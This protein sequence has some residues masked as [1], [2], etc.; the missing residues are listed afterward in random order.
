MKNYHR[1]NCESL[2]RETTID[3]YG[4]K[5][6]LSGQH[7]FEWSISVVEYRKI[8]ITRYKN[9]SIA[10]AEFKNLKKKK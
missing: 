7:A 2:I 8:T 5:V 3:K 1:E 4:R 10:R 6:I 9:G